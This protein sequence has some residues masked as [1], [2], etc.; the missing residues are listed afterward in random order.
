MSRLDQVRINLVK[1][2]LLTL[3]LLKAFD[4][5]FRLALLILRLRP[6]LAILLKLRLGRNYQ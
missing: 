1:L 2:Y 3:V 5:I 4:I 6:L